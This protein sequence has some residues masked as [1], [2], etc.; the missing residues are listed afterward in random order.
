MRGVYDLHSGLIAGAPGR[1]IMGI[2]AA[3]W[4]ISN[5]IGVYLT[6]PQ[7]APFWARWR[8][9]WTVSLRAR[10]PRQL[11]DLHRA[12]GLWLVPL[13][14]LLAL[15]SVALNFYAELAQPMAQALSPARPSPFDDGQPTLAPG[16]RP[17]LG[18]GE[19]VALA[20][21]DAPR[22]APGWRPVNALYAPAVGVYGLALTRSGR[23][24]YAGL[25]PIRL[26]YQG[27]DGRFVFRDDPGRDSLGR[28]ALRALYPLHSGEVFGWPT[29]LL[30]FVLGAA[31]VE[32]AA[33]GLYLWLKRR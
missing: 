12:S 28:A 5:L 18:W 1:W 24:D 22:R 10:L 26:Y 11:L 19:A 14:T 33:T 2:V 16:H 21:A 8:P 13:M 6:L 29:R 25:G 23:D 30:V 3:V 4:L 31:T 17:A 32:M 9:L 7:R 20:E 15:T 27:D